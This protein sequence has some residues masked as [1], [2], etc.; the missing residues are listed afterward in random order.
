VSLACVQRYLNARLL[1]FN[2]AAQPANRAAACGPELPGESA[3]A[4]EGAVLPP[5]R[6]ILLRHTHR[7][8]KEQHYELYSHAGK[9]LFQEAELPRGVKCA[10]ARVC[11]GA[12]A[13]RRLAKEEVQG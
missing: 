3:G 2:P 4:A 1:V 13:W 12:E 11:P 10:F 7:G 9:T 8:S 6:Y 5:T